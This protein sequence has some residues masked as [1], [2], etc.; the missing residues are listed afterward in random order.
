SSLVDIR[1]RLSIPEAQLLQAISDGMDVQDSKLEILGRSN[2]FRHLV[3][4][5]QYGNM[6][7]CSSTKNTG[8]SKKK[9]K[10]CVADS[11]SYS[12]VEVE[13]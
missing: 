6:A 13:K 12:V 8:V 10:G 3:Y 11:T 9:R 7:F 4:E 5:Y 1:E 2:K